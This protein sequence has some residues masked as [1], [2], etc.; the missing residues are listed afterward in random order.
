MYV[1]V[2]IDLKPGYSQEQYRHKMNR[3]TLFTPKLHTHFIIVRTD[4]GAIV[5]FDL[6]DLL[7]ICEICV[8]EVSRVIPTPPRFG[9]EDS[10][11]NMHSGHRNYIH[12]T[13]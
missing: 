3:V 1:C 11:H 12:L 2:A 8:C 5:L 7:V 13:L 4:L 10:R 9:E 6:L